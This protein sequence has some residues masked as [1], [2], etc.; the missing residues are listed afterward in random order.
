MNHVTILCNSLALIE[1]AKI[2]LACPN[3]KKMQIQV[4]QVDPKETYLDPSK[5]LTEHMQ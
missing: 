1:T 3:K 2:K 5:D 4:V